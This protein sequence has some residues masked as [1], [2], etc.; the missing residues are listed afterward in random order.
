MVEM[1]KSCKDWLE[2]LKGR[3]HLKDLGVDG[4]IT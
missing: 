3:S 2:S 1:R 4:N